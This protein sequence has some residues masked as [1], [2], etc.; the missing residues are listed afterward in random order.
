MCGGGLFLYLAELLANP[1]DGPINRFIFSNAD[2][3]YFPLV[4]L[5]IFAFFPIYKNGSRIIKFITVPLLL[6]SILLF[7][8][9]SSYAG[10]GL[11][12]MVMKFT[13]GAVLSYAL[14]NAKSIFKSIYMLI[15]ILM[16]AVETRL[17]P[18]IGLEQWGPTAWILALG[19]ALAIYDVCQK[20]SRRYDL[21][22]IDQVLIAAIFAFFVLLNFNASV[23]MPVGSLSL[24]NLIFFK[25]IF[26]TGIIT[27]HIW[28]QIQSQRKTAKE[29]C[30]QIAEKRPDEK[31]SA[32][33]PV[34]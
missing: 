11:L 34:H 18:L 16:I 2:I 26:A 20:N 28:G 1:W 22:N 6:L 17:I 4:L 23:I 12:G 32:K 24:I 33:V 8:V 27:G 30:Q 9:K 15:L 13:A 7:A 3:S 21:T 25:Y 10:L 14:L 29:G 5:A 19:T 31:E